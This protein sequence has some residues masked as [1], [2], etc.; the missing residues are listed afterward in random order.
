M[1][2]LFFA[3][4][5]ILVILGIVLAIAVIWGIITA[6]FYARRNNMLLEHML[7]EL[8]KLTQKKETEE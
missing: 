5:P 3:L 1:E 4:I 8:L 6:G 2:T 7:H